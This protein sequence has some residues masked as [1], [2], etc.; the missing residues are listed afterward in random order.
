M[1]AD[2]LGQLVDITFRTPELYS[3]GLLILGALAYACQ[4]YG[5]FAGYSNMAI[6]I[7][8]IIGYD[9]PL[10]FNRPYCAKTPREFWQRWHISLSTWLRDYLYVPLG[11]NQKG[12]LKTYRN[13]FITML[14]GGLWHGANSDLCNLGCLARHCPGGAPLEPQRYAHGLKVCAGKVVLHRS[15]GSHWLGELSQLFA[16]YHDAL[17]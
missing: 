11:G 8:K 14:L 17:F 6:G 3:P 4:I 13:L 16:H 10:N 9:L 15:H 12:L 1:I 7:A 5:D 2:H